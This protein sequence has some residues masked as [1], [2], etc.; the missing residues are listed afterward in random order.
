MATKKNKWKRTLEVGS[1]CNICGNGEE[2]EFHAVIS[3]TKS[4]ALRHEMRAAWELPSEE[5]LRYSG[6]DW[7]QILLNPCKPEIRTKILLLLWR[8][9]FLQDDCTHNAGKEL[10]SRSAMFLKQYVE[11]LTCGGSGEETDSKGKQKALQSG[12][13]LAKGFSLFPLSTGIDGQEVG[14]TVDHTISH[15]R[16]PMAGTVTLNTDA[17]FLTGSGDSH[18]GAIARDHDGSVIFSLSEHG[19]RCKSAEEAEAQALLTGL[20]HLSALYTGPMI[21]ETDCMYIANELR[22]G[23]SSLSAC[24]PVLADIKVELAKFAAAQVQHV[25][26]NQNKMAHLLAA[27]ARKMDGM[28]L[29]ASVP[30]DLS[31][32]LVADLVL[33]EE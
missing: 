1:T 26:R 24:Y 21:A 9:W 11:E 2:D 16:P 13:A 18:S 29:V 15:W 19:L 31:A 14:A 8:C 3:C 5:K 10:V 30:A 7:L 20:R 4:R 23:T 6:D 25:S 12:G 17:A 28:Y 22:S 32:A 33:A 27:R